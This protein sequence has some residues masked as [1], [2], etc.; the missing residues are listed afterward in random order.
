MPMYNPPHPGEFIREELLKPLDLS[1]SEAARILHVSRPTLSTLLNEHSA[2]SPDMAV[3]I[4][5]AF[6]LEIDILL[7]MQ[8][9]YD[10]FQT[11]KRADKIKVKRYEPKSR[12]RELVAV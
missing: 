12:R 11:R 2:V 7:G 4:E 8:S 6:G 1:V 3:R 5:K 9:A 10:I